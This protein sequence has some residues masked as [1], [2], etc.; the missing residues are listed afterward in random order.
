MH[1]FFATLTA[2][3]RKVV[4]AVPDK[5]TQLTLD[6][7]R[8]L[9]DNLALNVTNSVHTAAQTQVQHHSM[10]DKVGGTKL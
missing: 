7:T 1:E 10:S 8:L 3:M 9:L 5:T 6:K 2:E 4:E